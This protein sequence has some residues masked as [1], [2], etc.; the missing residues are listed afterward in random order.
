MFVY[1]KL[2]KVDRLLTP[3]T[4]SIQEGKE[5]TGFG[6]IDESDLFIHSGQVQFKQRAPITFQYHTVKRVI[7]W[8]DNEG[9]VDSTWGLNGTSLFHTNI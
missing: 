4:I 2:I 5:Y 6:S 9:N 1:D 8:L 7:R 3:H